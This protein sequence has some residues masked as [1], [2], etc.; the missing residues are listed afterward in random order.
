[1]MLDLMD[2]LYHAFTINRICMLSLGP[3]ESNHTVYS[4]GICV[5]IKKYIRLVFLFAMI[6]DHLIAFSCMQPHSPVMFL[7]KN[8]FCDCAGI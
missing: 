8:I 1:M 6:F 5:Q 4:P 3:L 2:T 7:C